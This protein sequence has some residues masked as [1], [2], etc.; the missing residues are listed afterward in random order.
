VI[1]LSSVI[2]Q[3]SLTALVPANE[4]TKSAIQTATV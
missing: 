4:E 3:F 1:H 2:C